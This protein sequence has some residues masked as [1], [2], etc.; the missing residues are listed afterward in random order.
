[1]KPL[2]RVVSH[3]LAITSWMS[4][5]KI[6][7]IHATWYSVACLRGKVSDD[8]QRHACGGGRAGRVCCCTPKL[9]KSW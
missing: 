5:E 4:Y 3:N 7:D 9:K 1:M 8:P 6:Y 2:L